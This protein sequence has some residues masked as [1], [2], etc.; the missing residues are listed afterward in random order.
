MTLDLAESG[1]LYIDG[2]VVGEV[3]RAGNG[4]VWE[5]VDGR[6]GAGIYH[7]P[8]AAAFGAGVAIFR[9]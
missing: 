9:G 5:L 1:R 6:V 2:Y 8:R 4:W 3:R 7:N